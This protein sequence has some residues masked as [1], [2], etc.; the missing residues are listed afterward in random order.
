[1]AGHPRRS[2]PF[3]FSLFLVEKKMEVSLGRYVIQA[4]IRPRDFTMVKM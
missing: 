2:L 4:V 1:M 3:Y